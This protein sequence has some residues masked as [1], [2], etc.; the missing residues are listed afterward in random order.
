MNKWAYEMAVLLKNKNSTDQQILLATVTSTDP[1]TLQLYDLTVNQHIYSNPDLKL[2][3]GDHVI[4]LL[5]NTDGKTIIVEENE[6]L[7]IWIYKTLMTARYRYVT[8]TDDYGSELD[9]LAGIGLSYDIITLEIQRMIMEALIYSPYI[10]A[11][12]DFNFEKLSTG[13]KVK[14]TVSSIYDDLEIEQIM[15]GA[16]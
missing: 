1:V 8:Y 15:E 14:F 9:D 5:D 16:S 10:T 4:V 13:I 7:K 3:Y 11:I 12:K 2:K 6:A